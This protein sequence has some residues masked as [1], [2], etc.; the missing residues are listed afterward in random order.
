MCG[1]GGALVSPVHRRIQPLLLPLLPLL[2]CL[3]LRLQAERLFGD[4]VEPAAEPVVA[5]EAWAASCERIQPLCV[6]L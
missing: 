2:L 4:R 1:R 6:H 5:A 3:V